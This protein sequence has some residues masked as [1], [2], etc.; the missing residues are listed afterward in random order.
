MEGLNT[1]CLVESKKEYTNLLVR[2]IKSP[3]LNIIMDC[4]AS[5]KSSCSHTRDEEKLLIYFQDYLEKIPEWQNNK[6]EEV[7]QNITA[8]S[9]CDY[10]E[11][12]LFAVFILHTRIF[13][14]IEPIPDSSAKNKIVFPNLSN[15][16]FQ[17]VVNVA[18]EHWK[19]VY[20]F[21]EATS[22]CEYQQNRNKCE[23]II[24]QSI[25][26][27]IT[28]MLPVRDILQD[29]IY[30]YS[31]SNKK[32]E[33]ND[34]DDE[35]SKE[36]LDDDDDDKTILKQLHQLKRMNKMKKKILKK[37]Q[38]GG[39]LSD[40]INPIL[41]NGDSES[42]L[43]NS[44][45]D[46]YNTSSASILNG[47]NG[48]SFNSSDSLNSHVTPGAIPGA[49]PGA[50]Q[51]AVPSAIP[52]A[53]PGAI[54]GAVFGGTNGGNTIPPGVVPTISSSDI[55]SVPIALDSLPVGNKSNYVNGGESLKTIQFDDLPPS[56]SLQNGSLQNGGLNPIN[57]M[58]EISYE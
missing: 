57:Q 26:D 38:S 45:P 41:L 20:L 24:E 55:E 42:H 50:I 40:A 47:A 9:K 53:V 17:T 27:T 52:G 31:V 5:V 48:A 15:F 32:D 11:D 10:L 25:R 2:K 22:S 4:F 29:H 7:T 43:E 14:T 13:D 21:K 3:I 19:Y 1:S 6:I 44:S 34:N 12:V 18:R 56:S 58:N 16:L 35:E 37:G 33:N 49:V 8:Q 46:I 28:E 36:N 39:D 51:G 23:I 30:K 54:Q